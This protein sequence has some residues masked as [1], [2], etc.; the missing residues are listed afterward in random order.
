MALVIVYLKNVRSAYTVRV[1]VRVQ[2]WFEPVVKHGRGWGVG[3][4]WGLEKLLVLCPGYLDSVCMPGALCT[5]IIKVKAT[6]LEKFFAD[7]AVCD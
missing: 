4:G 6:R 5:K 7:F 1:C 3:G 2:I